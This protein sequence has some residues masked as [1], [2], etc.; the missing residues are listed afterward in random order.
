MKEEK[1]RVQ[2]KEKLLM[3]CSNIMH[4][5]E[6][7][8]LLE[9][10]GIASRR[11]D[12]TLYPMTGTGLP[13]DTYSIYVF[14]KDYRRAA[15]IVAPYAKETPVQHSTVEC[16]RCNSGNVKEITRKYSTAY[17]VACILLIIVPAIYI[18]LPEELGLRSHTADIAAIVTVV[19]GLVATIIYGHSHHANYRCDACGSRFHH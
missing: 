12:K 13:A 10:N 1:D 15:E 8:A 17:A 19:V 14:E 5:N 11:Q 3:T 16:P 7:T 9:H 2:D 18:G 6:M 4:A